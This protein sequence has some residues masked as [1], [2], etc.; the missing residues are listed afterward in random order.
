MSARLAS[1]AQARAAAA[2]E[3]PLPTL[4]AVETNPP[5]TS[6]D[7]LLEAIYQSALKP[8]QYAR[9][10]GHLIAHFREDRARDDTPLTRAI[11]G[12]G[13]AGSTS[14]IAVKFS[15]SSLLQIFHLGG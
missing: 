15:G 12:D 13:C 14:A 1:R 11:I 6:I 5:P 2:P 8:G 10:H 7:A 3:A 4:V 9:L